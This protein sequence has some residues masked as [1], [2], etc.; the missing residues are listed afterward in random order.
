MSEPFASVNDITTLWRPLTVSE[1]SR[2]EALLPL[3]SDELRVIAK[4][5]GKDMDVMVAADSAYASVAKIVTVDVVVRVLRQTTEG[6]AMTQESQSALGYSW[7]GTYAV[8]GGGI[9]NAIMNSDLKKLGLTR[10]TIG[11]LFTWQGSREQ[12]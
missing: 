8:P 5:V 6:D 3:V 4:G 11:A 7:S 12:Q 10:Q 1:T 9:A 2:A